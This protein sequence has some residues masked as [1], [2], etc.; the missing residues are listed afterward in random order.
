MLKKRKGIPSVLRKAIWDIHIGTNVRDVSC[1]L[2]L[3][4]RITQSEITGFEIGHVVPYK[5]LGDDNFSVYY[6]YPICRQCN[7]EMSDTNLLDY[8]FARHRLTQLRR[9]IT[10]VY[11]AY[12]AEFGSELSQESR[13]MWRILQTLYGSQKWLS[14]GGILNEKA[15][16]EIA[17]SENIC[18]L[19]HQIAERNR[20]VSRL[21]LELLAVAD[22]QILPK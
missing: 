19:N 11:H 8:L 18:L 5:W 20:E 22:A 17:R 4:N 15:I 6:G 7:S 9:F 12:L 21:V 16:Y 14:G 2:C 3:S 13:Q 1:P 10:S